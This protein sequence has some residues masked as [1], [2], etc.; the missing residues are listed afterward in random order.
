MAY[1]PNRPFRSRRIEMMRKLLVIAG[2]TLASI[3]QMDGADPTFEMDVRPIFKAYCLDCHGAGEKMPGGLDLRLKRFAESGGKSGPG[4]VAKKPDKSLIVERMKSGE[5]P[6]GEK[7]VPAEQIAIVEKWI[8]N[9]A[10][11]KRA[12]PAT[13]P[14]GLGIT[15]DERAYWFYQ[16]LNRPTPPALAPAERIRTPID[17]FVLAKLRA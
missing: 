4:F 14:P 2:L 1:L 3:G 10:P 15:D 6:P 7:K 9:G 5:M 12:E 8:A 16:P 17:A 13:L 11:V